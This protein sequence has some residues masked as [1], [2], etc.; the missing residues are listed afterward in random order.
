LG[1]DGHLG[2]YGVLAP[3]GVRRS[4]SRAARD[5]ASPRDGKTIPPSSSGCFFI[6]NNRWKVKGKREL[7]SC[8]RLGTRTVRG[9]QRDG[10]TRARSLGPCGPWPSANSFRRCPNGSS[11]I[12]QPGVGGSRQTGEERLT[13][14][15][16]PTNSPTLKE[17][18]QV[19]PRTTRNTRKSKPDYRSCIWRISRFAFRRRNSFRVALILPVHPA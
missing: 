6:P 7:L 17:L 10:L 13:W 19:Q 4:A 12:H 2:P 16:V 9:S 15:I 8:R 14:E 18:H 3:A 11:Q 5:R 1:T